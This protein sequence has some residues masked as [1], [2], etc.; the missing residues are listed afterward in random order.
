MNRRYMNQRIY[1]R[2]IL[3]EE[4]RESISMGPAQAYLSAPLVYI[5]CLSLSILRT[6]TLVRSRSRLFRPSRRPFG[7]LSAKLA[8]IIFRVWLDLQGGVEKAIRIIKEAA[9]DGAKVI[10]FPE[11]FIPG[12]TSRIIFGKLAHRYFSCV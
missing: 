4:A 1:R 2:L 6:R 5:L 8:L 9:A 11:V 3:R 10:G 7:S 12:L